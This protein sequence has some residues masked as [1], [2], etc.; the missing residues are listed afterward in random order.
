MCFFADELKRVLKKI[1]QPGNKIALKTLISQLEHKLE[2]IK[3]EI[4]TLKAENMF[5]FQPG[6]KPG[7]SVS[8][9][10]KE[11]QISNDDEDYQDET[12]VLDEQENRDSFNHADIHDEYE[13][14]FAAKTPVKMVSIGS[15]GP[16]K[17]V[18]ISLDDSGIFSPDKAR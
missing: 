1:Q 4:E 15:D 9:D 5:G 2:G 7:T 10:E 6:E 3:T 16:T 12:P 17:D 8:I 11:M 14:E 13:F 18:G